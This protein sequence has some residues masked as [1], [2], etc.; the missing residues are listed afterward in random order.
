MELMNI[1]EVTS[2][3]YPVATGIYGPSPIPQFALISEDPYKAGIM[4]VV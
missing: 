3:D 2:S 1:N 4:D